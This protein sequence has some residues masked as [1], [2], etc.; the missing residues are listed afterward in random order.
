VLLVCKEIDYALVN[1]AQANSLK[2]VHQ[3]LNEKRKFDGKLLGI[4][5]FDLR[6][7]V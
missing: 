5:K 6:H 2:Q 4:S 3:I 7:L 1:K